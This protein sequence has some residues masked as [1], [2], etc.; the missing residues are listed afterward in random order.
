ME[1]LLT[2][3]QK[4]LISWLEGKGATFVN[5]DR[6]IPAI[7]YFI[8][9]YFDEIIKNYLKYDGLQ[10]KEIKIEEKT[11]NELVLVFQSGLLYPSFH[12]EEKKELIVIM[13]DGAQLYKFRYH[14]KIR[15]IP[16]T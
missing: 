9:D 5:N 1:V 2:V 11:D 13:V 8:N 6:S 4:D 16:K 14:E 10:I 7:R 3:N 12:N 15:L